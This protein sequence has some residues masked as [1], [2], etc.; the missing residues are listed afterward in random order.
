[1]LQ[2]VL[3]NDMVNEM[4]A[5]WRI[6]Q[7]ILTD[8]YQNQDKWGERKSKD[9]PSFSL[10]EDQKYQYDQEWNDYYTKI[11]TLFGVGPEGRPVIGD[12]R[13]DYAQ[14]EKVQ[15]AHDEY[16][17]MLALTAPN[18]MAAIPAELKA[19]PAPPHPLPPKKESVLY[20][21]SEVPEKRIYPAMPEPWQKYAENDFKDINPDGEMA[22]DFTAGLN[23]TVSGKKEPKGDVPLELSY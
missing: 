21:T 14:T 9:A 15:K 23:L 19:I 5:N 22:K 2:G 18:K 1:M 8:V 20:F 16:I 13:Y 17:K 3:S 6:G 10:W 7:E 11:N 4:F 12:E